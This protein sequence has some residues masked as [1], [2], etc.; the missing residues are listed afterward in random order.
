MC[1][2]PNFYNN[3]RYDCVLVDA[4]QGKYFFVQL[5]YIVGIFVEMK[6]YH[7]ALILPFDVPIPHADRPGHE[8]PLQFTRI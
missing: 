4:G 3:P 5:L 2:H 8:K 6:T 7:I 1:A